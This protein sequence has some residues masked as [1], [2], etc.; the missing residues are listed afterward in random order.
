MPG[1]RFIDGSFR[2]GELVR[3]DYTDSGDSACSYH[4]FGEFC[5]Y[6]DRTAW[7]YEDHVVVKVG[8]ERCCFPLDNLRKVQPHLTA[9]HRSKPSAP[10]TRLNNA[11]LIKGRCMDYG[12]GWGRDA[13]DF[14]M[15]KYDTWFFPRKPRGLYDTILCTYVLNV[16]PVEQQE[17]ILESIRGLLK[18]GGSAYITVRRAV[19]KPR[20]GRGCVI[21]R[22]V[23]MKG[24]RVL[25]RNKQYYTYVM[26][27]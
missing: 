2:V 8:E 24:C 23:V 17:G 26:G 9:I 10:A 1:K 6:A 22:Q 7:G 15:D 5:E 4:G 20:L 14:G 16:V 13:E 27:A 11:G 18:P 12:C 21:Q 19:R 3:V 25:W